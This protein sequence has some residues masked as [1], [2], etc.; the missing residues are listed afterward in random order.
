MANRN[1]SGF[2]N[3]II[4]HH[5]TSLF[6]LVSVDKNNTVQYHSKV[7]WCRLIWAPCIICNYALIKE[8][9]LG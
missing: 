2:A 9:R 8:I 4:Y 6:Y 7:K 1:S 5:C 3:G